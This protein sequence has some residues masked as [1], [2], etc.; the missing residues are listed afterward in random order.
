MIT[1]LFAPLL[2]LATL[3]PVADHES[4]LPAGDGTVRYDLSL[5]PESRIWFEGGSTVRGFTCESKGF[6][7]EIR[8]QSNAV[9]FA[10]ATLQDL[11]EQVVVRVP[12]QTIDCGNGTMNDHMR[13]AL[14]AT[15]HPEIEFRLDAYDVAP[16]PDGTAA[17]EM[18]GTLTI[19]GAMKPVTIAAEAAVEEGGR[20]MVR[21]S[22]EIDMTEY[23]VKPPRLMLGTL[24]VHDNVTVHFEMA[25][26]K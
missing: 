19:A 9:E 17:I 20:L 6:G 2:V 10:V 7:A 5:L 12:V 18:R 26:T 23:G 25:L 1:R 13:K 21:G 8:A 4:G 3:G 16:N 22:H 11:I 15:E 14:Q 24:K